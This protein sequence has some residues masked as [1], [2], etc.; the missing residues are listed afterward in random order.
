MDFDKDQI[1]ELKRISPQ[2]SIAEEGGYSYIFIQKLSLPQGCQPS[3]IDVL[4]CP[5]ARDGYSSR[6]FF[7]EKVTGGRDGINWNLTIRVL[8]R[9]WEAFSWRTDPGQRLAEMLMIHLSGLRKQ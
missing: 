8:A 3:E 1:E 4:L 9:N 6:L 5:T 7:A 2:I